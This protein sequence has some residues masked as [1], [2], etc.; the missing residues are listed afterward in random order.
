MEEEWIGI[1]NASE[2]LGVPP[3]HVVDYLALIGDSSDNI[4]GAK[5]IGPKTAIS[6]IEEYGSVESI[7][8]HVDEIKQ[9]RAREVYEDYV[10]GTYLRPWIL[11]PALV[12]LFLL[13][14]YFAGRFFAAVTAGPQPKYHE[15]LGPMVAGFK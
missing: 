13:L 2:R 1:A 9:K 12:L 6:L 7:L 11:A 5:G 10:E 14:M 3:G 8:E 15:G 4:P